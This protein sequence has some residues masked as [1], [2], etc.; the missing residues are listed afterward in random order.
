[1]IFP[2]IVTIILKVPLFDILAV[3]VAE[4]LLSDRSLR[5]DPGTATDSS[6]SAMLNIAMEAILVQ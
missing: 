5:P 6:A 1:M 2:S 3:D 4:E